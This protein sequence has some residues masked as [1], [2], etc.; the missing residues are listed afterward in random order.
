MRDVENLTALKR[1]TIYKKLNTDPS[2]PKPIPLSDSKSPGAPHRIR[3]ER[4]TRL[5]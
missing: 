1:S 3:T 2:F 5:D 4:G